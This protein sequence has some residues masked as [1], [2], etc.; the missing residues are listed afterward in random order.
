MSEAQRLQGLQI[1]EGQRV[2]SA[3]AAG[4]QYMMGLRENRTNADLGRA[5]GQEANAMQQQYAAQAAQ[6]EAWGGAISGAIS[7]V[8][9]VGMA[10]I[11]TSTEAAPINFFGN[12][13][14]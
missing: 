1:S 11:A 2:Q 6:S 4:Q 8:T 5:A 10:N 14:V 9:S 7:G 13:R 12:P 3:E